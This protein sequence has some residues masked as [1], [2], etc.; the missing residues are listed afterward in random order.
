MRRGTRP[1]CPRTRP[2]WR[3]ASVWSCPGP[4]CSSRPH[5]LRRRCAPWGCN[6]V[7]VCAPCCLTRRRRRRCSWPWRAWARCG[8]S[9]R[10]T[11]GRWR[12]WTASARS[13]PPCWWPATRCAGPACCTTSARWWTNCWQGCPACGMRC[14][15]RMCG[16][17]STARCLRMRR[18]PGRWPVRWPMHPGRSRRQGRSPHSSPR[19]NPSGCLSTTRCGSSTPAAPPGCPN[20]SCMA[21]VG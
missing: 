7:T 4:S 1:S 14:G 17:C 19:S 8:A 11:W 20:P 5:A 12:C 15:V 2:A 13:S 3:V 18:W 9:A 6:A 21:M 10:P 16:R